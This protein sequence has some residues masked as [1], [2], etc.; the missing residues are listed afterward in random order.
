MGKHNKVSKHAHNEET[1]N[2]KKKIIIPIVVFVLL[3]IVIITCCV[4]FGNKEDSNDN[5]QVENNTTIVNEITDDNENTVEPED[6]GEFQELDKMGNYDALGV[7]KIDKLGLEKNI[8]DE[9]TDDSLN[10]SV[11]KFYGPG[12]NEV[13]NFC[14]TGH[15][16]RSIFGY[17]D[18]LDEG[19][20]FEVKD[21]SNKTITYKI[22]DKYIVNTDELDCLSQE[23]DGKREVTL[24]TCTP[25][26]ITRLIIKAKEI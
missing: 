19:D 3:I 18:D 1:S 7:L 22:Y 9:T 21:K 25:G 11:T 8:L 17:L 16:Y 24:I 12:I 2:S 14:I 23:T 5:K 6:T 10:L 15:N 13:G 26:G 20:T 4:A